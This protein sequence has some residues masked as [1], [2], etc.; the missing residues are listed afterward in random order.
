VNES[1]DMLLSHIQHT[2]FIRSNRDAELWRG[3]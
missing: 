3:S 2:P 1:Q